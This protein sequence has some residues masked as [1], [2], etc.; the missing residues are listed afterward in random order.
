MSAPG[1]VL[2]TRPVVL[3]LLGGAKHKEKGARTTLL[4][5]N[6]G[7]LFRYLGSPLHC[8]NEAPRCIE[9]SGDGSTWEALNFVVRI[10]HAL[11]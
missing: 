10:P 6:A 1:A 3:A 11:N 5:C 7:S 4:L 8:L 9:L 2:V